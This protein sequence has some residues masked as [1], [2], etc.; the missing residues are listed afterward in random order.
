MATPLGLPLYIRRTN[1]RICVHVHIH[2]HTH[3]HRSPHGRRAQFSLLVAME[4][5]PVPWLSHPELRTLVYADKLT[6]ESEH[7]KVLVLCLMGRQ[8]EAPVGHHLR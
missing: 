6:I 7:K 3:M 4:T 1:T 5:A 2:A 8:R